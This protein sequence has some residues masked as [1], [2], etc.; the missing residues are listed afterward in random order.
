MLYN[1]PSR[2]TIAVPT[3]GIL[4]AISIPYSA[5]TSN[6]F[7]ETSASYSTFSWFPVVLALSEPSTIPV[8]KFL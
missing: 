3:K 7:C 4:L 2:A 5:T 6:T 1:L 8:D